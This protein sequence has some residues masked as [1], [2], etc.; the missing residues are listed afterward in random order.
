[1]DRLAECDENTMK[2]ALEFV[3]GLDARGGTNIS[4]AFEKALG[5]RKAGDRPFMVV[6]L[7]DGK[8]TLGIQNEEELV[9]AV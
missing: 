1:M 5:M 7:T 4:E 6:F 9:K 8:P 2:R 3:N